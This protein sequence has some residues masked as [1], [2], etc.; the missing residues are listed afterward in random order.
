ML[1]PWLDRSVLSRT[2]GGKILSVKRDMEISENRILC[3]ARYTC[4]EMIA[5]E[6][7]VNLFGSEQ[8]YGRTNSERGTD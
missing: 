8:Y 1:E 3:S 7:E 2:V 4:S 6:Q 5:R